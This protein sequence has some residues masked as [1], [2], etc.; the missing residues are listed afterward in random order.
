M[1]PVLPYYEVIAGHGPPLLMV[2]G[3]LSS[4]AQWIPNV[5]AL[6]QVATPV[7]VELFGHGRSA[8]PTDPA[9]YDPDQYVAAFEAIRREIGADRWHVLGYS[10]G[11]GLTLRYC[12][13]HPEHVIS[14]MFTNSTSAFAEES[15]TRNIRDRAGQILEQYARE[16][17]R[18][19]EAIPVH[20]KNAR[21]L[22]GPVMA[23]LLEDC[24][25]L[26]PDGVART[27]V[28]TNGYSS[29]RADIG[30][31][32]VP[33]LLLCGTFEHRFAPHRAFAER[34][35]KHLR[36]TELPAG[37]AVNAEASD[38]FNAAVIEFISSAERP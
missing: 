17:H 24:R 10:L 25:L 6:R 16:G 33:A 23:A 28:Y 31:N 13:T 8:A 35:M 19:I 26:D 34:Q 21:R 37:H 3:I 12:L 5:Q 2:H 4:R 9:H 14:Q 36:V 7:I 22:P 20:P 1:A 29:V 27:I 32:Q 30:N 11:A 18:A 15:V 38:Q